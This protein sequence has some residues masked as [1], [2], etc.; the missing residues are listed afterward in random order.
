MTVPPVTDPRWRKLVC[1][2]NDPP[3]SAFPTKL[4]LQRLRRSVQKDPGQ[5]DAAIQEIRTFFVANAFAQK[6]IDVL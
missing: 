1:G 4:I 3:L 2:D 5:V 6:D